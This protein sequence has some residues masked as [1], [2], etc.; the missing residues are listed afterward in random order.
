MILHTNMPLIP[1]AIV[2]PFQENN[3]HCESFASQHEIPREIYA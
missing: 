1:A 2:T 3:E